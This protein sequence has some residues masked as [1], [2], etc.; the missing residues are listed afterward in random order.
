M[1][2]AYPLM[3]GTAPPHRRR[4]ERCAHRRVAERA[5]LARRPCDLLRRAGAHARLPAIRAQASVPTGFALGNALVIASYTLVDGVGARLSGQTVAYTLWLSLLTAIPLLAVDGMAAPGRLR[6]LLKARWLVGL[7]GGV[8]H[9]RILRT[10]ALGDDSGSDR[11]D[12]GPAR[13]VDP[14]RDADLRW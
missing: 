7:A 11:R 5:G 2:Y 6:E 8:V 4:R 9:A 14:V 12:G 13:D 10:R 3:R 1:S